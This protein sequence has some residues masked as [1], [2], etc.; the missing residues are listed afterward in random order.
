[1]V[2]QSYRSMQQELGEGCKDCGGLLHLTHL[3]K[4][5]FCR[6]CWEYKDDYKEYIKRRKK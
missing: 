2:Q 3:D 4:R 6:N 5:L 1:M